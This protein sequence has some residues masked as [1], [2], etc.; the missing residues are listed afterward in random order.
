MTLE[1]PREKTLFTLLAVLAA[2]FWLAVTVATVG[3]VWLYVGFFFLFKAFL[4]ANLGL[5]VY[6][7]RV[8]RLGQGTVVEQAGGWVMQ[9]DPVSVAI[10]EQISSVLH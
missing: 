10:A 7:E 2:V 8:A 1:Y 5:G 6:E 4:M 3:L 9:P